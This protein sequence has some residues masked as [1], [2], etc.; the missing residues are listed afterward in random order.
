MGIGAKLLGAITVIL[1]VA[2]AFVAGMYIGGPGTG[3]GPGT[4]PRS[5]GLPAW[6]VGRY[7]YYAF[8]T[9]DIDPTMARIVVATK[10]ETQ[11]QLGIDSRLDAQRHAVLNYNP[12]LGRITTSQLAVFEKGIPQTILL[13]PLHKGKIWNFTLLGRDNWIAKVTG[14]DSI[15]LPG[16]NRTT[17]AVIEASAGTGDVLKYTYD[18]SAGWFRSM[19]LLDASGREE[20]RMTLV[21][22]GTGYKGDAYFVRGVDLYS[23][24]ASSSTGSPEV[25]IYESF[26][27]RGHPKW[28]P[29]DSLIYYYNVKIGDRS[30]GILTFRDHSTTTLMRK[31]FDPGTEED[32]LGSMPS[33]GGEVGVTIAL[34]G[35]CRLRVM[36]AGGIEYKWT[37]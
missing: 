14:L 8:D 28:G 5:A 17:V 19:V 27:D 22:S 32:G 35:S 26:I 10:N 37:L 18:S 13:F 34:Q 33:S 4:E 9:P 2:V 20:L 24:D 21:S 12:M 29:F 11:Y 6:D 25:D 23:K 7:W 31:T 16:E 3:G 36:V 1:L 30:N 15:S